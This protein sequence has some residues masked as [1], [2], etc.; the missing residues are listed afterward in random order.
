M[1]GE[2]S[3]FNMLGKQSQ[4]SD[5]VKRPDSTDCHDDD[6]SLGSYLVSNSG[7]FKHYYSFYLNI[8]TALKVFNKSL[9]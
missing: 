1:G 5:S 8:I 2:C 6:Q 7:L 9:L 3:V 4:R